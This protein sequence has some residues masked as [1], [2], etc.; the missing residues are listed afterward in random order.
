MVNCLTLLPSAV[1][2]STFGTILGTVTDK[3]GA[4]VPGAIINVTNTS[5][6]VSREATSDSQGNYEA[7]NL[8]AGPYT[9]AA[10]AAGFK[11]FR[12]AGLTLD[13]RQ[14]LRVDVVLEVGQLSEQVTV[15]STAA[16]INT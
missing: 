6:N 12:Q 5:R 4:V 8:N 14:T 3:S 2:Q 1:A 16:V 10:T 9:V 11:T 7:L 15:E 13:A